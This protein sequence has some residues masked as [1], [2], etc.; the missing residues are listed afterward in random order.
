M[1]GAF[2]EFASWNGVIRR[3]QEQGYTAVVAANPIRSL[4]ADAEFLVSILESLEG[5]IALVGHSYG[6]SAT[7]NSVLGNE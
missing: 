2:A 1:H 4:S 5:L 7:S 6:G 3:V